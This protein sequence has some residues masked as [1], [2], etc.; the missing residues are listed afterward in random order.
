ML[1]Y[2]DEV[3][4]QQINLSSLELEMGE[5]R[6]GQSLPVHTRF[7]VHT[8]SIPPSGVWVQVDAPELGVRLEPLNV[9]S[10]KLSIKVADA[11]LDGD[12]TYE[13]TADAHV[14]D[15]HVKAQGSIAIRAPSV[16]KLAHDLGLDQTLPHD[17]TTLGALELTSGW[18]Y[19]DGALAAKPLALK[20][21][22]VTFGGWVE[23]SAS[24]Q[25]AWRFELHGDRIDLGRY[26]NVDS[27]KKKPFE[28]PVE[29]LRAIKANGSLLFDQAKL[30]DARMSD[31]RL[32]FQTPEAKQ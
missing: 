27:T 23:R 30:A 6:A 8:D 19:M 26:V 17:P 12:F 21:D 3:S 20:L 22:G 29:T 2:V 13:Q 32:R 31:V 28:L 15:A 25:S 16:R 9:A 24:P 7:L 10:P 4:G 14:P 18:S 11:Q 1:E 5:W